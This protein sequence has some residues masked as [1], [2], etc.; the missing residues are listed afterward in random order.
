M[1]HISL[2]TFG[3]YVAIQLI[4]YAIDLGFFLVLTAVEVG[5]VVSNGAAKIAAGLFAFTAHR[6]V[7]FGVHSQ[8]GLAGQGLRY[9]A[10]LAVNVPLASGVL[11]LLLHWIHMPTLAKFIADVVCVLLT[12]SVSQRFVFKKINRSSEHA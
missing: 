10:L 8:P 5:P 9:G 11:A 7:T 12:F 3:R 6:R 2:S 1:T 4:A